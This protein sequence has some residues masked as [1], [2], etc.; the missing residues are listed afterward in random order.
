MRV[1][2][3]VA[4][5]FLAARPAA[6]LTL[7]QVGGHFGFG[8]GQLLNDDPPAGSLAFG[9]GVDI[10]VLP[11]LRAGIDLGFDLLGSR[12]EERG[13]VSAD[14]E[15]SM[16]EVFG[17][18][19]WTP[20]DAWRLSMGPGLV[21]A[22]GDLSSSGPVAFE[23]LAVNEAAPGGSLSVQWLMGSKSP[24]RVGVEAGVRT[25]WMES[26]TWTVMLGRLMV[27]Y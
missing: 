6:A 18:L 7:E 5:A 2:L 12:V 16:F 24:L 27:H 19:H 3:L 25:A 21:H 15:Y 14:V 17:L 10:P 1:L 22:R 8:Y 4:V 11:S 9:A 26:E 23:D 13:S 20:R